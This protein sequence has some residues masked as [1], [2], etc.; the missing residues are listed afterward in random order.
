MDI[1]SEG[2]SADG[3]RKVAEVIGVVGFRLVNQLFGLK[4]LHYL[5][6]RPEV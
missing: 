6:Y 3:F 4:A 5:G 2:D 1:A